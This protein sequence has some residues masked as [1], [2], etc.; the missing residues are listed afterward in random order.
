MHIQLQIFIAFFRSGI[1]GFGGG[2]TTIPLVHKEVV[3][4]FEW[5]TDEEFSDVISIGNTLPGPVATKMAGYI[6]YRIGGWLGL[7]T[8]L[9]ATVLPT[10]VL[11]IILLG[12][13]NQ[14]NDSKFVNGMT[15]GVIPIVAVMM[16]ALTWDFMKKAKTSLGIKIAGLIFI[17]SFVAMVPLNIHP[18]IVISILLILAF[19]LPVKGEKA[20]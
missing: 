17:V 10:V 9:I 12:S 4:K 16:G 7:A 11:M 20:S 8:A 13:L 14:F 1:L 5:M 18:G 19:A 3:T 2:P 15:N 6:G